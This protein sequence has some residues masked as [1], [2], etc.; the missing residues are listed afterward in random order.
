MLG[1]LDCEAVR[2]PCGVAGTSEGGLPDVDGW[3]S[4]LGRTTL[5]GVCVS[6]LEQSPILPDLG[7]LVLRRALFDG[8]G[9][10]FTSRTRVGIN[11][12]GKSETGGTGGTG[13]PVV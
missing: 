12:A 9:S 2:G 5:V 13:P 3:V 8:S 4:A 7:P 6:A 1:S 11:S 10:G